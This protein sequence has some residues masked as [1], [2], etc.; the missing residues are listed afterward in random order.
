MVNLIAAGVGIGFGYQIHV[1]KG[2]PQLFKCFNKRN[3]VR[4]KMQDN[5]NDDA[6]KWR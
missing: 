5:Q 2:A 1:F 4:E 3:K 6:F